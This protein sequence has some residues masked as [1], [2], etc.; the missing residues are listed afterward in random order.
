MKVRAP[1]K[2]NL[3]LEIVRRRPDGYHELKTVFQTIGLADEVTVARLPAGRPIELKVIAGR[4]EAGMCPSDRR[5]IVWKAAELF[6][7]AFKIVG[8]CRITLKKNAPIQAGLGGGS[9]DAAAAL[10]G[11]AKTFLPGKG[12]R[13]KE[14]KLL[15]AV[16]KR[17]GAD[18]P[19]FLEGGCALATGIGERIRRI[20]PVPRF[21]AVV[22][23]PDFGCATPEVY[24]WYDAQNS[25][26]KRLTPRP[27]LSRIT[28][29]IGRRRTVKEWAPYLYN[30]FEEVVFA[31]RP[32]LANIKRTLI[33]NG[34]LNACLSG[35]GSA[36]YGLA[37][38]KRQGE[39]IRAA[40]GRRHGRVWVVPS[41]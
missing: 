6:F 8:S 20:G 40:L 17:C 15:R 2:V 28:R 35:S 22:V 29:P 33:E 30:S 39:K 34:A 27:N 18:V 14:R 21:W 5:N 31:R 12:M 23:K 3:Y 7:Q 37:A 24:G 11:L 9:S 4:H 19:F 13:P 16:A 1:A 38:S 32:E 36:V 41:V 10:M 26:Q 25:T